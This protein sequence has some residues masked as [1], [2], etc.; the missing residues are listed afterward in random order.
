MAH[1]RIHSA[2]GARPLARLIQEQ[3]K[4]PLAEEVLFGK[5]AHGGTVRVDVKDNELTF[6]FE[7]DTSRKSSKATD[8]QQETELA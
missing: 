7:K 1:G 8:D 4:K 3:I 6:R 5:L 2:S